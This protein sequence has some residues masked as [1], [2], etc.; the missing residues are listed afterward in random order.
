MVPWLGLDFI[1]VRL[2]FKDSSI[3]DNFWGLA[4][5]VSSWLY[6]VLTLDWLVVRSN[7][8]GTFQLIWLDILGGRVWGAGFIFETVR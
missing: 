3:I 8:L 1:G 6:F 7:K 2:S 4:I 5:V